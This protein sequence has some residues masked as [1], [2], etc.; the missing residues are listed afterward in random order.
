MFLERSVPD[1]VEGNE[2]ER[3]AEGR[4]KTSSV[5][6]KMMSICCFHEVVLYNFQFRY[7]RSLLPL[8]L[9]R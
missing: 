3:R 5:W 4:L 1:A 2:H 8:Y 7:N 9:I 6:R